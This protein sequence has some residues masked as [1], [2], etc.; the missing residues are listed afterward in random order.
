MGLKNAAKAEN[1]PAKRSAEPD[2][3]QELKERC[4]KPVEEL[5]ELVTEKQNEYPDLLT[6]GSAAVLVGKDLGIQLVQDIGSEPSLDVE[7]ITAGM[8]DLEIEGAIVERTG[9]ND[10]DNG[11]VANWIVEDETGRTQVAFWNSDVDGL[12][13]SYEPGDVVRIVSAYTKKSVSDYQ[14]DRFGVPAIQI[15]DE[16]EVEKVED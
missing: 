16:T 4:S 15:G 1:E 7:N 12:Y 14:A 5:E 3:F 11:K 2:W 10:F 8:S 13:R 6:R 9:V